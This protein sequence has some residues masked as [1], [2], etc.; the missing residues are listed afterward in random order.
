MTALI[1]GASSGIGLELA[2][3]FAGH[4]YDVVLVARTEGRLQ[5][6]AREL[7]G[8]GVRA[9]VVAADLAQPHAARAVAERVAALGLDIDALANDAG[10]GLYGPFTETSLDGELAMI[11]VNIVA[12]TE[13]TKQLLP[14]MLARGRGRILNLAST[15]A[16]LPGPLMAVYYATKAYTLSFSEA[17]ANELEG[18][19]VTVT[20]LCPGPTASGFQAAAHLEGSKLVAGRT[21]PTA[22]EVAVFGYEALMAG[23]VVAVPGLVNKATA[24]LPRFLPRAAIRRMVRGAQERRA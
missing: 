11:Q 15:A 17:L 5:E 22:R 16:F 14:G 19:G 3:V 7:E 23:T 10:Y 12:L 20:A 13:L 9:H 21:L 18:S 4:R 6:L 24:L 1:T 8:T 2:R